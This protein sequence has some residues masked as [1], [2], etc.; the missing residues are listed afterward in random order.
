MSISIMDIIFTE[1]YLGY[2]ILIANKPPI[3]KCINETCSVFNE[4]SKEDMAKHREEYY[5]WFL[6]KQIE[7]IIDEFSSYNK[8]LLPSSLEGTGYY[9]TDYHLYEYELITH[10]LADKIINSNYYDNILC[11]IIKICKEHIINSYNNI[12]TDYWGNLF[13]TMMINYFVF[14]EFCMKYKLTKKDFEGEEHIITM[15]NNLFTIEIIS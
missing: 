2:K 13:K 7:E 5:L 15:L 12:W 8:L 1:K 11:K 14:I 6:P 3:T 10:R 9:Y 4:I